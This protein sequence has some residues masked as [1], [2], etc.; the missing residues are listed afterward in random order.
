MHQNQRNRTLKRLRDG[1]T[2]ILVATDVAARGIDVAGISHVVNFDLPR[3]A[4]D[5]VHRIGRTGRAGRS[6][7]AVSLAGHR[8]KRLVQA[9]ERYTGK[10]IAVSQIAGLEPTARPERGFGGNPAVAVV[11]NRLVIVVVSATANLTVT[12]VVSA[13]AVVALHSVANAKVV[14]VASVAEQQP[15]VAIASVTANPMATANALAKM[16]N[17]VVSVIKAQVLAKTAKATTVAVKLSAIVNPSVIVPKVMV[18]VAA[19]VNLTAT[20]AHLH[21]A[22][23]NAATAASVVSTSAVLRV[24]SNLG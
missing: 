14:A 9:I 2:R 18:L 13:A 6:G 23:A 20:A 1:H 4:E 5:Y 24:T 8:D 16:H 15:P 19:I 17:R 11:A 21:R 22:V 12:V 3:Q 10:R 7:V